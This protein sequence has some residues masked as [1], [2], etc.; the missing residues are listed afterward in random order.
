MLR[1]DFEGRFVV[2]TFAT[3]GKQ[4]ALAFGVSY[5]GSQ[6]DRYRAMLCELQP[7]H[8]FYNPWR[9]IFYSIS[10]ES[11]KEALLREKKIIHQNWGYGVHDF[12]KSVDETCGVSNTS[13]T[14]IY[15]NG[16]GESLYEVTVGD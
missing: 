10:D 9:K 15:T 16:N 5:G 2:S 8:I 13:F 12:I 3:A 7:N 11:I 4:P 14:K 1:E 6:T